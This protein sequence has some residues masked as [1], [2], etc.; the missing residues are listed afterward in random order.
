MKISDMLTSGENIEFEITESAFCLIDEGFNCVVLFFSAI[1]VIFFVLSSLDDSLMAQILFCFAV[2]AA[3]IVIAI[4]TI[5]FIS[6]LI[7]GR[8]YKWYIT[9][10]KI[11]IK[12]SFF[13]REFVEIDPFRIAGITINQSFFGS[14]LNY[15]VVAIRSG[16]SYGITVPSPQNIKKQLDTLLN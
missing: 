14:I 10:K 7:N 2:I 12:K 6:W 8:V 3:I 15:G 16:Y 1:S 9:N 13:S 4:E 11:Y 5:I